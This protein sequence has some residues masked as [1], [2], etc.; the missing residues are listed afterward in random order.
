[1]SE[2]L[3]IDCILKNVL[4]SIKKGNWHKLIKQKYIKGKK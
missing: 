3:K 4:E 1:M 2:I